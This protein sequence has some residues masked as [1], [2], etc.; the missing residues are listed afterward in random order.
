MNLTKKELAVLQVLVQQELE[1]VK[2]EGDELKISNSP[3]LHKVALDESDLEFLKNK[4]E[5][6]KFL[7]GL[8]KKL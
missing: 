4:A 1:D 5:Y 2:K 3:F 6:Q 8:L 7:K